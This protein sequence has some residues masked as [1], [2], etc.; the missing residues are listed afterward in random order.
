[1]EISILN[2]RSMRQ[3]HKQQAIPQTLPLT[4]EEPLA[5]GLMRFVVRPL[6]QE[7]I[8]TSILPLSPR[9]VE[10]AQASVQSILPTMLVLALQWG[11]K[12][13]RIQMERP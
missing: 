3:T 12:C 9:R 6:C 5:I 7:H 8:E 10:A 1:M 2:P 13:V 11:I 4:D